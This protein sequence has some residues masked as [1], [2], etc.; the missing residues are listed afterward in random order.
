MEMFVAEVH[1]SMK[2]DVD[3][4]RPVSITPDSHEQTTRQKGGSIFRMLF[5]TLGE[6]AT[7]KGLNMF[8]QRHQYGSVTF[9]DLWTVLDEVASEQ[10]VTMDTESFLDPWLTQEHFPL[11]TVQRSRSGSVH[12]K[13]ELFRKDMSSQT[14]SGYAP[15]GHMWDIPMM[16]M[17]SVKTVSSTT[18]QYSDILWLRKSQSEV[19]FRNLSIPDET[20]PNGWILVNPDVIG[21]YRVNYDDRN[22]QAL[23][24]QLKRDHTV[25]SAQSRSQIINDAFALYKSRTL[26]VKIALG[27]LVYLQDELDYLPWLTAL[28]EIMELDDILDQT[29][30]YDAFEHYMKDRLNAAFQ[31]C[32]LWASTDD[33]PMDMQHRKQI[34]EWAC[35]YRLQA[36][37]DAASVVFTE[38]TEGKRT[39]SADVRSTMYCYGVMNGGQNAW[40]VVYNASLNTSLPSRHKKSLDRALGCASDPSMIERLL[41]RFLPPGTPDLGQRD[42][43]LYTL[44]RSHRARDAVW[45]YIQEHPDTH[46]Y[47][48]RPILAGAEYLH[49][50]EVFIQQLSGMFRNATDGDAALRDTAVRSI[51]SKMAAFRELESDLEVW[52]TEAGYASHIS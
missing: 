15:Y 52:L 39:L 1:N 25:F 23:L 42:A 20:D 24:E 14:D 32:G 34:A 19:T 47:N 40:D 9:T 38:W 29:R 17:S 28:R 7:L 48:L 8:L 43:I 10:N 37:L 12:V 46:E 41:E 26:D 49:K 33:V 22:W 2:T 13:Q 45:T 31:H 21:Y 30:L 11:V 16:I 27:T 5:C 35:R 44:T 36:C 3:I 6:E 50:S 51:R 4:A 18:S